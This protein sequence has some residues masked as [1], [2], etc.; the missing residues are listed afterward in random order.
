MVFRYAVSRLLYYFPILANS[1]Q[2]GMMNGRARVVVEKMAYTMAKQFDSSIGSLE[3]WLD[4]FDNPMF[5]TEIAI[6]IV[7]MWTDNIKSSVESKKK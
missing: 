5:A 3:E 1:V 4:S 6:D 7:S 2:K